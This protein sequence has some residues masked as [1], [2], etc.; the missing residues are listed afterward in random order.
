MDGIASRIVGEHRRGTGR[1]ARLGV[2][3][4]LTAGMLG[5]LGAFGGL[6][7]AANGV[8]RA[9]TAAVHVIAPA[10]PLK[11]IPAGSQSSAMAQY[12]V[13]MC[14]HGHTLDVDSH[15][16]GALEGAGAKPGAC[17]GG[18]FK[19]SEK[20]IIACFKGHNIDLAKV[21][22]TGKNLKVRRAKL[23]TLHKVGITL[24]FC[25]A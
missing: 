6:G 20:L 8:T 2:A 23:K 21:S 24:G 19:P 10:K 15:A 17:A 12:K 1:K 25:K 5:A 22:V 3:V 13:A 11:L 18:S 16:V 14:F 4:A 7:Y 9:V